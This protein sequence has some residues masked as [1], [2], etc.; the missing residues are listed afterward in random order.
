MRASVASSICP[1]LKLV[2]VEVKNKKAVLNRYRVQGKRVIE[3]I[4][5]EM[6]RNNIDINNYDN[7]DNNDNSDRHIIQGNNN[8]DHN[9]NQNG[10]R[11]WWPQWMIENNTKSNINNDVNDTIIERAS[12]DECYV[13]C[14]NIA[15]KLAQYIKDNYIL[16]D[17]NNNNNNNNR[18]L[19]LLKEEIESVSHGTFISDIGQSLYQY[20]NNNNNNDNNENDNKSFSSISLLPL[21]LL[22]L[23]SGSILASR[24]RKAVLSNLNFSVSAGI[25]HNKLMSKLA[26]AMNKPNAQTVIMTNNNNNNNDS[27][28]GMDYEVLKKTPFQK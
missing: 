25:S 1:E 9:D 6:K 5:N 20:I 8:Y 18:I 2:H 10:F 15:T 28:N 13:D 26:S 19:S 4:M 22:L 17:N 14:T 3:E 23:L 16:N 21:S 12:I 7:Y 27:G 24:V 11:E